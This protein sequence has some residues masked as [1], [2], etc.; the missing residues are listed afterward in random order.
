MTKAEQVPNT[1]GSDKTEISTAEP[2]HHPRTLKS[3]KHYNLEN[4]K[5]SSHHLEDKKLASLVADDQ[6]V[7]PIATDITKTDAILCNSALN[8]HGG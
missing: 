2:R 6:F 8:L 1:N 3:R 5:F 7:I 4:K